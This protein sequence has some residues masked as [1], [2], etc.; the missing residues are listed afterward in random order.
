[1][2]G[3]PEPQDPPTISYVA[4]ADRFITADKTMPNRAFAFVLGAGASRSSGI[5]GAGQMVD[6]WLRLRHREVVGDTD[7][8]YKAWATA[9]RLGITHYDPADPAASYSE[10]YRRMYARDPDRGYAYLEEQMRTAEPSYGYSVLARIMETTRHKVVVTTNFDNLVA[11][12]LSIFSKTYPLVCGHESLAGFIS[13]RARRPLVVKVHRDLLLAPKSAPEDLGALPEAFSN[14][15]AEIFR[16][17][18]PI[19]IGYGGNDG[20]L[21]KFLKD[22]PAESVPG[23]V[24]WCY[25]EGGEPPSSDIRR[26]V[27]AQ[28][29]D[30]VPIPG[31]DEAMML[32]GNAL[33]FD[34]PDKFVLDRAENRA[35]RIVEQAQMLQARTRSKKSHASAGN[36]SGESGAATSI[37][38][39]AWEQNGKVSEEGLGEIDTLSKAVEKTMQRT[40]GALRWWQWYERANTATD[41]A[42]RERIYQLAIAALPDSPQMLN[43][44]ALFLMQDRKDHDKAEVYFRKSLA[45]DPTDAA[46]LCNYATFLSAIRKDHDK[47]ESYYTQALAAN[48]ANAAILGMYARFLSEIRKQYDKAEAYYTQALAAD[49]ANAVALANYAT[50]LSDARND[51]EKAETY[52]AQAI[53]ENP[54]AAVALANYARFLSDIRKDYDK[55]ETYYTQ[56]LAADSVDAVTLADY[57]RFLTDIRKNYDKAEAFYTQALAAD[58]ANTYILCSYAQFLTYMRKDYDKAETCYTQALAADPADPFAL[59]QY[60]YFLQTIRKDHEKAEAQLKHALAIA[61]ID[62]YALSS[63]ARFL[64]AVQRTEEGLAMLNRAVSIIEDFPDKT[65]GVRVLMY[66]TC[67]WIPERWRQALEK[68]KRLLVDKIVDKDVVLTQ[69]IEAAKERGHP[70]AE[71]LEPLAEVCNGKADVSTLEAWPAW[72]EA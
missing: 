17:Y 37:P 13:A 48:P 36:A 23:G 38:H 62:A 45:G 3:S 66:A 61:P 30:L 44:Y 63:Y 57:A 56:A 50:F 16:H 34:V 39:S 70:A 18:T 1:M 2:T 72:R 71:W 40:S 67:H 5:K 43:C 9:Q 7:G 4:L 33:E 47:A 28:K 20:S 54:V 64:F 24:Y 68:L 55:A 42:E 31:F 51:H 58:P 69:V 46:T 53:A 60:S 29:G 59:R 6:D 26:F 21:M 22:L 15:L 14:A 8:D 19:V 49:P 52:Y 10:L 27:A 41:I 35:K 65:A 32:F 12:S 25:W 11:D